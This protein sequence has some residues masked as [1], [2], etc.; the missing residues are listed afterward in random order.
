MSPSLVE[1]Q[2]RQCTYKRDTEARSRNHSSR[3]KAIRITYSECMSAVLVMKHAGRMLLSI[4]S[5]VDCLAIP[6]SSKLS[7]KRHNFRKKSY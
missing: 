2:D 7:H 4:L 6:Y 5:P 3:R 1:E